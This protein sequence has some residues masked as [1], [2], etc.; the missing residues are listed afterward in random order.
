MAYKKLERIDK[1]KKTIYHPTIKIFNYSVAVILCHISLETVL[2]K[3]QL[4]LILNTNMNQ[5]DLTVR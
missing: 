1:K 5:N 3:T 4:Y 2:R